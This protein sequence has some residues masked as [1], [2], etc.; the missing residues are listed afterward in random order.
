M[1]FPNA[2]LEQQRVATAA[3][4]NI[5]LDPRTHGDLA[6]VVLLSIVYFIDLLAIVLLLYNRKYPP[7]KSK[8]PIL[9]SCLFVCSVFWFIGDVE[10]NGHA[11]LANSVFTSCRGFGIWVRVLLGICGVCAVVALRSYTLYHV[12]E[13]QLPSRGLRFYAPF[14]GYVACI[15]VFGIVASAL[16]PSVSAEYLPSLDICR[17]D[18]PFKIAAFVFIWVTSIFVGA[19][20]WRIRNIKSSFNE[21]RE[22]LIACTIVFAV[23]TCNT[24]V[25][26]A[27]PYYPLEFRFRITSTVLDHI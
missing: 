15:L 24:C 11:P 4:F 23:L 7:L 22:M 17:L 21:S 18:E 26:F 14:A 12:F 27:R 3:L 13:L 2:V 10:V 6:V 19:I 9:M 25:Q 20:N 1:G 16:S 8:G 5:Q